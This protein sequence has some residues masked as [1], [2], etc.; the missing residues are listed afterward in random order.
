MPVSARLNHILSQLLAE[1]ADS[2][3]RRSRLLIGIALALAMMLAYGAVGLVGSYHWLIATGV[4]FAALW[5]LPRHWWP[6]LFGATIVARIIKGMIE[7]TVSGVTGPFFGYWSGPVQFSL[8]NLLE[9]FLVVAGVLLLRRWKVAPSMPATMNAMGRLHVAAAL[10]A[11]AVVCK[12]LLYVLN[13]GFVADVRLAHIYNPVPIG[14]PGSWE[15]LVWFVI[16]N[17]LG[18]F[19]GIMLVAPYAF[20]L[21]SPANRAGSAAILRDMLRYALPLL[22]VLV[23]LGMMDQGSRLAE[24]VRLLMMVV[25]VVFA[26]RHGWRGAAVSVFAASLAVALEE[27]LGR[28]TLS[29]I[30]MQMFIAITGAMALLFGTT[31]DGLRQHTA[32]LLAANRN[33]DMLAEE[34][35]TAVIHTLQTEERERQRLAAELHDEFGQTLTALQTHLKLAEPDFVAAGR[36]GVTSTLFELTRTM[37]HNIAGV[38][39]RLR[40]TALDE[41]GLF[42][43]IERG[44]VR[45][46]AED[47]GLAFETHI[48]GDARLLAGL[49]QTHLLAAY[50]LVQEAVTNVVRHAGASRCDVR[51]RVNRRA[52]ALWLFLDVR[53][54]GIGG[55]G[56]IR[57][58]N[59]LV[60]MRHRVVALG[61]RLNL[62]D[63]TTGSRLHALLKQT[64]D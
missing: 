49:D 35:H 36:I 30:E 21:S 33:S 12:D 51:L 56:R 22:A 25:V 39:E 42:A 20:W 15:L 60:N 44:S 48:E 29:P 53:D 18:D 61:G 19:I 31:V 24:L 50:R 37:R 13:D 2:V 11:M 47:A 4:L 38:L 10:S 8:G 26:M 63:L 23:W 6:W 5:A 54:D 57:P 28:P 62:Q 17:F 58:G 46:L 43:A 7:D 3:P 14:G 64:L 55:I 59:G 52:N 27:Y 41:L 40:P 9:P 1:D 32:L 34:L 45:R 16:K